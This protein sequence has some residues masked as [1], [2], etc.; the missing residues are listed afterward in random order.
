MRTYFLHTILV[1]QVFQ[2]EYLDFLFLLFLLCRFFLQTTV[3]EF[4]QIKFITDVSYNPLGNASFMI[5]GNSRCYDF[6]YRALI[7]F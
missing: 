7:L 5:L 2:V 1:T 4:D 6:K 3:G